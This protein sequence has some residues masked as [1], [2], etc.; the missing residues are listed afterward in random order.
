MGGKMP[1]AYAGNWY[2]SACAQTGMH[3]RRPMHVACPA[4]LARSALSIS[5]S[6]SV[7]DRQGM[8]MSVLRLLSVCLFVSV[9]AGCASPAKIESMTV[10]SG[11]VSAQAFDPALQSN[12]QLDDVQGGN[13]TNPLWTSEIDGGDFRQALRQSLDNAGLL[14]KNDQAPLSLSANLVRVEQP[15]FGL[16]FKVT[17]VVEYVLL[18]KASGKVLLRHDHALYRRSRRRLRRGQAFAPGQRRRGQGKHRRIA[19]ASGDAE[20]RRQPGFPEPVKPN[21]AASRSPC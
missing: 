2:Y 17:T 7:C 19:Q 18:D 12:L 15:L 11:Q 5:L 16:D 8:S 4:F 9:L 10:A 14:N 6:R 20:S 3:A 1:F 21:P 13:K